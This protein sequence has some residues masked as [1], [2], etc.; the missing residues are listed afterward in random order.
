MNNLE[1]NVNLHKKNYYFPT[2]LLKN[3]FVTNVK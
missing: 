1:L 3:G 2:K